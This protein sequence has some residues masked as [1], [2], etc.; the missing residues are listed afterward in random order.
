LVPVVQVLAEGHVLDRA[1]AIQQT[2]R[3]SLRLQLAHHRQEGCDADTARDEQ[4]R[5]CVVEREVVAWSFDHDLMARLEFVNLDG[6]A[7]ALGLLEYR[8]VVTGAVGRVTV[9]GV[10][11]YGTGTQH[12]IDVCP[13]FPGGWF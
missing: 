8:D 3:A 9:Q 11:P 1:A 5:G 2:P 13:R 6:S 7:P 10:L 4:V 12:Q